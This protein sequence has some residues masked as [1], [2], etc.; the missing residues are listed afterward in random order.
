MPPN[1]NPWWDPCS[2]TG[3]NHAEVHRFSPLCGSCGIIN[4]DPRTP[5]LAVSTAS[6]TTHSQSSSQP[7]IPPSSQ[8]S[9]SSTQSTGH[10]SF[11][12]PHG[13]PAERYRQKAFKNRVPP[14]RHAASSVGSAFGSRSTAPPE[15]PPAPLVPPKEYALRVTIY[16]Q[17]LELNKDS[18]STSTWT[19]YPPNTFPGSRYRIQ[20]TDQ[21]YDTNYCSSFLEWILSESGS[22]YLKYIEEQEP[23]LLDYFFIDKFDEEM[24]EPMRVRQSADQYSTSTLKLAA[25]LTGF[26][27]SSPKT[28]VVQEFIIAIVLLLQKGKKT[29]RLWLEEPSNKNT[30]LNRKRDNEAFQREMEIHRE[31]ER[32]K[33]LKER[34]RASAALA[35]TAAS[36]QESQAAAGQAN[37]LPPS[38][39]PGYTSE[40]ESDAFPSI[41]D[42]LHSV[43]EKRVARESWTE[44]V[45]SH[46]LI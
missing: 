15:L 12:L 31:R 13:E 25:E 41:E 5:P 29:E 32:R 28:A 24:H 2:L 18:R 38:D 21:K 1:R 23:A 4:P 45:S 3:Y 40:A 22:E 10:F 33:A 19:Y 16:K 14:Q 42:V 9:R 17:H 36:D 7:P 6:S 44:S 26:T 20:T 37:P 39:I 30:A 35:S 43:K 8:K 46:A 27:R 11:S 34:L